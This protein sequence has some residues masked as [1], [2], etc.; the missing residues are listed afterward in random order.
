MMN[1]TDVTY[2]SVPIPGSLTKSDGLQFDD[3]CSSVFVFFKKH[4]FYNICVCEF[5]QA[6]EKM[7]L[8]IKH[9]SHLP[10]QATCEF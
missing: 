3:W 10:V 2:T 9:I 6:L 5:S 7:G 1:S 8:I 4:S